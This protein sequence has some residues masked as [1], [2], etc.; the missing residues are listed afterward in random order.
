M[1]KLFEILIYSVF[2]GFIN[3]CI[4]P[5]KPTYIKEI[6]LNLFSEDSNWIFIDT[7][8]KDE[9]SE[10]LFSL[11]ESNFDSRIPLFLEIWIPEKRVG[12]LQNQRDI[13]S[14]FNI[15]KKLKKDFGIEDVYIVNGKKKY[16]KF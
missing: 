11:N 6:Y 13:H 15:A 1:R 4:N 14:S 7:Q 9:N 8:I 2:I 12:V 5:N 16:E 3:F 10:K